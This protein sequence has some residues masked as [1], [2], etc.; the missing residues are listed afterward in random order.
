MAGTQSR[1]RKSGSAPYNGPYGTPL[2]QVAYHESRHLHPQRLPYRRHERPA[3]V[4]LLDVSTE[5]L[6]NMQQVAPSVRRLLVPNLKLKTVPESLVMH[7]QQLETLDL[8]HNQLGDSSFPEAMK[9]L[10]CLVELRLSGNQ[11]T[12]VPTC[13]RRL[14]NLS[15]LDLS[16]NLLD[17]SAGLEKLKKL[18]VLVLD[19]NKLNSLFK[20][21]GNLRRLQILRCSGNKIREVPRDIRHLAAL[22]D[23]DISNNRIAVLPTDVFQLPHLEVL[24]ASQNQVG[25]IPSFNVKVQNRHWIST[26][27]LSEN[28]LAKFPGHLMFLSNKL[29]L[30]SNKIRILSW[31]TLKKLDWDKHQE[32]LLE[33]NPLCYP[34]PEVCESGLRSIMN[35]FQE[36]QADVKT[37]QGVKVL[38]L[39]STRSGKTS[40]VHSLVDQ[41]A[42]LS[43][44]VSDGTAGVDAYE[45]SFDYDV[46]NGKPGK[47]LNLCVWDFCGHP[48]YLYPHYLFHEHPSV[49]ILTFSMP[50]YSGDS[51]T[52][53]VGSWFDWM[54]AKT[55]KLVVL[56]VGT[57]SDLVTPARVAEITYDVRRRLSAHLQQRQQA[58]EQ[59][60]KA[61]ESRPAISPSLS[62]QL[63]ALVKLLQARF[64]VQ[65]DVIATSAKTFS[66]F[67]RLRQAVEALIDDR[68]LFP[69]VM[70][71]IPTFWAEVENWV[72]E[73][74]N[75]LLV[76]IM[77]WG[78]F[79]EEVTQ[80]F[81][82]KHLL[83]SITQYLHETG[84]VLWF[85]SVPS[86][87]EYVFLR[88]SWLFDVLKQL[89]RHDLHSMTFTPDDSLKA[90]GFTQVKF[91]RLKKEALVEG[92]MDRELIKALLVSLL[93]ADLT[94]PAAEV[95]NLLTEGL[96]I[97][98]PVSKRMR[99]TTYSF[100]IEKDSQGQVKVNKL[101]I[102]WFRTSAEP[103]AS[104]EKWTELHGR[105]RLCAL[106]RFP[107]YMPPGLFELTTVR[108][109]HEKHRLVF[110]AHWGGGIQAHHSEEKV[111][112]A[113]TYFLEK[114]ASRDDKRMTGRG[115]NLSVG[116]KDSKSEGKTESKDSKERKV[117]DSG[118][119]GR[120]QGEGVKQ[121]KTDS[122]E[123]HENI[124][125][126]ETVMKEKDDNEFQDERE[127]GDDIEVTEARTRLTKE[128]SQQAAGAESTVV[129]KFEIRDD[130][131]DSADQTPAATMWTILLP[132]L[133]DFEELLKGYAGVL[134]ERWTGCPLCGDT[135]FLGEWLAPKETQSM[136]TRT[137][138]TC[139]QHVDTAFL[140]QP[141]EKK[142]V[143]I[144]RF[145]RRHRRPSDPPEAE[146]GNM[147]SLETSSNAR[148][149]DVAVP[150]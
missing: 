12:K 100:S 76:P 18:Q 45:T 139:H 40:L 80:R 94:T 5:T 81:G 61:I 29:D 84:K 144:N 102:P 106:F 16:H 135:S 116:K 118:L 88:P 89:L 2:S 124:E 39:G 140:V 132:L 133:M 85:S 24:N 53:Q 52:Q 26:V 146:E 148:Y 113:I 49:T 66:G 121:K 128:D 68:K 82:M 13:V 67:G 98:Y 112:I 108:V 74:G 25:K 64:V 10:D 28:N 11:L 91:E 33:S 34:P 41:Q 42:R 27:D 129:V 115:D 37:Y 107:L 90:I 38:V 134:V 142:R 14:R 147:S 104:R 50:D 125:N 17:S 32:L 8:S 36:S 120:L 143:V 54:I 97:G 83:V 141:R 99:E 63:K 58:I 19:G 105:H 71:E 137:C 22:T 62:E 136:S 138:D 21:I 60:V 131:G 51:F 56:L 103:A 6:D 4:H 43:D 122:E 3:S 44:D 87:K 79:S 23:L 127:S 75:T 145:S 101:L 35:F 117:K 96:E 69:N 123:P 47:S 130:S 92:V 30:S 59:R 57:K 111:R 119:N 7:L 20:D 93:P 78:E 70:R 48:F 72:E 114:S 15:R 46:D 149:Q 77:R 65:T 9:T 126:K 95:L 109:H 1:N 110:V 31:A 86:L 150:Q 55:N 73:R